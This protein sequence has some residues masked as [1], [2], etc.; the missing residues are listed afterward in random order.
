MLDNSKYVNLK[1]VGARGLL[2]TSH[3]SVRVVPELEFSNFLI[4]LKNIQ[5]L[6][7]L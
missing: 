2:P 6:S 3:V 4:L 1:N 7:T 5:Y